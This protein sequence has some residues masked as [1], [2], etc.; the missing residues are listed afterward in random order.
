[1]SKHA[2]TTG[3]GCCL[4]PVD[5]EKEPCDLCSE[6]TGMFDGI[7]WRIDMCRLHKAAPKLLEACRAA[8]LVLHPGANGLIFN[9]HGKDRGHEAANAAKALRAVIASAEGR[10]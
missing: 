2:P 10:A 1:M 9:H 8:L 4:N 5:D 7:G 3:C 6:G